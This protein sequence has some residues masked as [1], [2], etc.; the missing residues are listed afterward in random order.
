MV[1]VVESPLHE[2]IAHDLRTRIASGELSVG[3][4]LPSEAE[5]RAQWQG[6]R[7][8]VRQA[9][10]ALRADGL[11]AGGRGKPPVVRRRQLGQPFDSFVS[12]S[13][14][15]HDLGR[16][17]GQCTVEIARRPAAADVAEALQIKVGTPV[18]QLLRLRLI[19]GEPVMVERATFI[20]EYGSSLFDHDLDEGSIYELLISK[21]LLVGTARHVIDAVL[22]D[23][24]DCSLL[25]LAAGEPLLR[26][27]RL[28]HT[29]DGVAFEYSDDRYRPDRVTFT[30]DNAPESRPLLDRSW[31]SDTIQ[32]EPR[33]PASPARRRSPSERSNS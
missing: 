5:L 2:Q 27:R 33:P 4:S 30:I 24:A 17:P 16:V 6:S 26:E 11:I 7:G 3:S 9:L 15:V 29:A 18:V 21:G 14:W 20:A 8:P 32:A 31:H 25:K 10:A 1:R 12:F 19:D 22:A 23:E 13:R 28:A